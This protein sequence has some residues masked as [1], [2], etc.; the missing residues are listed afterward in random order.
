M[1]VNEITRDGLAEV[2]VVD[3]VSAGDTVF[4]VHKFNDERSAL[5]EHPHVYIF[6]SLSVM[7]VMDISLQPHGGRLKWNQR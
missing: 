1:A 6:S 2:F 4:G 5:T 7:L 3:M